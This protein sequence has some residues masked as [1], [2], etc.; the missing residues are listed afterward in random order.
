MFKPLYVYWDAVEGTCNYLRNYHAKDNHVGY[1]TYHPLSIAVFE[2]W[3][4]RFNHADYD[5]Q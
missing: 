4:Y 1:N 2:M 3:C 5:D